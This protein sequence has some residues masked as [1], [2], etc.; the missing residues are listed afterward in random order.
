MANLYQPGAFDPET[1][2]S[3]TTPGLTLFMTVPC[4]NEPSRVFENMINTAKG[5]CQTL[6]GRLTDQD[7]RPLSDAGLAAIQRQIKRIAA[8]ISTQG[9][10]PGSENALRFFSP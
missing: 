8:D 5:L 3:F 7:Q 4:V 10:S 9:I 2:D 6:G 1:L